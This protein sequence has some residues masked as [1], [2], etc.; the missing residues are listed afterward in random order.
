MLLFLESSFL[1]TLENYWPQIFL[2]FLIILV[3][4]SFVKEI[5][6]P[7]IIA[8]SAMVLILITPGVVEEPREILSV[9]SNTAPIIIACMFVLSAALE[10]TGVIRF[11]AKKFELLSGKTESRTFVMMF[12]IVA[13][14]SAFVSNTPVVVIFLSIVLS[15]SRKYDLTASKLLI[16]LSYAAIVGGTCT[17]I[18]TSTNVLASEIALTNSNVRPIGLFEISKLGIIFVTVTFLYMYF[19]GRKLLPNR[20]TLATLFEG[21][22]GKEYF[23]SALIHKSSKLIGKNYKQTQ[24]SKNRNLRIIDITRKG[25]LLKTPLKEVIF[26]EGDD[27][28]IKSHLPEVMELSKGKELILSAYE[29]MGLDNANAQSAVLMEGLVGMDS[30]LLNKSIDEINFK[31]NYG[32]IVL[33]IHRRGKNISKNVANIKLKFGDTLLVEGPKDGMNKLFSEKN[34]INLTKP[35]D[36]H[37][38]TEKAKYAIMGMLGF[39][40]LGSTTNL[41]LASLVLAC[42]TFVLI[43]G[44]LTSNQAYKAIEWRV[45]FLIIG[46]MGVGKAM[47]VTGS[48]DTIS[49]LIINTIG[50][51]HPYIILSILYLLAAVM[52]EII[53]NQAVAVLLTPIAIKVGLSIGVDPVP[54]VITVMFAASASFST[55]IGYQT[56]TYVY[57]AGGYKF[58]DFFKV[59]FP[60]AII[61]WLIATFVI[62]LFWKF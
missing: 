37:Y 2:F 8:M 54:F 44:C 33:A 40:I 5:S 10:N 39:L 49:N 61:L 35:K 42:V 9:L 26:E 51:T 28:L 14:L 60:L 6:S 56:N 4:V 11:L 3:F 50:N 1:E 31:S 29:E 25:K 18:G 58:F 23:T 52:T 7:D 17:L 41:D 21:K 55:P 43:T 38:K 27:L 16:P 34:F 48:A 15:Q 45:L 53:S 36:I 59:G 20:L 62:P 12:I 24:L 22:E 19:F 32:L 30:S 46:M 13:F 47:L 57:G